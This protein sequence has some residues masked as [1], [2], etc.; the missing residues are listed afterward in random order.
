MSKILLNEVNALQQA[1]QVLQAGSLLICPTETVY[2][3]LADASQPQ[4]I[5]AIYQLK[6]RDNSK[7]LSVFIANTKQLNH[8]AV[9]PSPQALRLA[10]QYWPGPL[11]LV[12]SKRPAVSDLITAGK[13]T[14]GIRI[15]DYPFLLKLLK[16]FPQG[17]VSTSANLSGQASPSSFNEIAP[18][19]LA[20]CQ[21]TIDGGETTTKQASTVIDTSGEKLVCLREGS[22]TFQVLKVE[23]L[24]LGSPD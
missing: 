15:P 6:Q 24:R 23:A 20:A 3:L 10:Q 7:P 13:T 4:A 14:I 18:E 21:L 12:F 22:L 8:W 5:A 11:T 2:G 9:N 19:L 17:L 1:V 16:H